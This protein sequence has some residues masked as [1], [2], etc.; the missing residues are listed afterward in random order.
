ME[1]AALTLGCLPGQRL[2]EVKAQAHESW[3]QPIVAKDSGGVGGRLQSGDVWGGLPKEISE[4]RNHN[5]LVSSALC[6]CFS[7]FN[8][9]LP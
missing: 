9:T 7:Y 4:E 2:R 5:P 6:D 3:M 1:G 8:K